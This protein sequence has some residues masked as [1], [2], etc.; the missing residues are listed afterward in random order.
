MTA[1][2]DRT[3]RTVRRRYDRIAVIYDLL[4]RETL[5]LHAWRMIVWNKVKPG[6][7]LEIGVGTG[8]NFPF[9]PPGASITA[10]DLSAAMLARARRRADSLGVS[11]DL[12]H[13]DIQRLDF[14]DNTFD[15]VVGTLVFCSVPDPVRGLREVARVCRPG[16]A[17][18]LLEHVLSDHPRLARMMR[19]FNPLA[20]LIGDNLNRRTVEYVAASGLKVEHVT[21]LWLDVFKLI[22]ARKP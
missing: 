18:L 3:T 9:Y 14:A 22:E 16:G 2:E 6:N 21:D 1:I 5:T 10:V 15:A 19:L 4:A 7:I 12:R 8:R 17:V 20:H 11:A 13:M